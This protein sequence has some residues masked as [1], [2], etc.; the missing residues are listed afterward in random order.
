MFKGKSLTVSLPDIHLKDIGKESEGTTIGKAS[1]EVFAAISKS[2]GQAVTG[3]GKF[4]EKGAEAVGEAA[5]GLG[6]EAGRAVEG[7]KGLF[8]K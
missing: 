4:L 3:S 5:K 2:V 7:V 1:S 6:S 8:G